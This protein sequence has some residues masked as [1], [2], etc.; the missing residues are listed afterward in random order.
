[1]SNNGMKTSFWGP[2]AWN[3]LFSSI[4]GAYP[5]T[6]DSSN[7]S[8]QKRV[9]GFIAMITSLKE[10]LPCVYCRNSYAEFI[11]ELPIEDYTGSR[12]RM[13][14]WLYLIHDKVNQKLIDQE[15]EC[16]RTEHEKL[17]KDLEDKRITKAKFDK[18][19]VELKKIRITKP[20]P[21]F[22][23]IVDKFEKQRA[24]CSA[25]SKTCA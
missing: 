25:R 18:K 12:L 9:K 6:Y 2:S 15:Q 4:A 5:I 13:M 3:F 20:S 21:S 19:F 17:K 8:Q 10:T 1:M 7:K 14:K 11:K 23:S 16:Y 24:G 22:Q